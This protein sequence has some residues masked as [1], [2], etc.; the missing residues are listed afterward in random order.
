MNSISGSGINGGGCNFVIAFDST[1]ESAQGHI[2]E[3]W[4]DLKNDGR[5]AK[6]NG[7]YSARWLCNWPSTITDKSIFE[8]P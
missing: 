8:L 1:A 3:N 7:F 5:D 4:T 6:G 2:D